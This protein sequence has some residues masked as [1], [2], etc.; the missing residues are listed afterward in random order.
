MNHDASLCPTGLNG[1]PVCMVRDDWNVTSSLFPHPLLKSHV[2]RKTAHPSFAV[3]SAQ[4]LY[5]VN[6]NKSKGV[7]ALTCS[8]SVLSLLFSSSG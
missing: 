6:N 1:R 4:N 2:L 7:F 5:G 3:P 8:G